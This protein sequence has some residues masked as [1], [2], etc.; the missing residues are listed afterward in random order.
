MMVSKSALNGFSLKKDMT[1]STFT[2][3]PV[4]SVRWKLI[5]SA[6]SGTVASPAKA[7][8]RWVSVRLKRHGRERRVRDG[9]YVT[10]SKAHSALRQMFPA[11]QAYL[12]GKYLGVVTQGDPKL[13]R[14]S[15]DP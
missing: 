12:S 4:C 5:V 9:N 6:T 13:G 15:H 8:A 11:T 3:Q 7:T 10:Y 1:K 14:R 2:S